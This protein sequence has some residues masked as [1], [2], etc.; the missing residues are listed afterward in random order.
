MDFKIWGMEHKRRKPN[1]EATRTRNAI[2]NLIFPQD[3]YYLFLKFC[4]STCV[5]K[6][7]FRTRLKLCVFQNW[8]RILHQN[9]YCV[10][11]NLWFLFIH[12]HQRSQLWFWVKYAVRIGMYF[13]DMDVYIE[14]TYLIRPMIKYE[15]NHA[16]IKRFSGR[17]LHN[18]VHFC[19]YSVLWKY[20]LI[21]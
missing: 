20:G 14:I 1:Q 5:W 9:E 8:E 7:V 16:I 12:V 13:L 10:N 6:F 17:K 3:N 2:E 11:V 4:K 21:D 15:K 19:N 18:K